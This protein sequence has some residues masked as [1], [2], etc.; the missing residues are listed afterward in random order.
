LK[1][2]LEEVWASSSALIPKDFSNTAGAKVWIAVRNKRGA[3]PKDM[4]D[5]ESD[6][7][8]HRTLT[9]PFPLSQAE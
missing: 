5:S 8:P 7:T 4:A 3:N 9:E 6:S 1:G 2:S